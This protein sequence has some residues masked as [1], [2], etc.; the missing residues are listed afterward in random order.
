MSDKDRLRFFNCAKEVSYLSTKGNKQ[1]VRIGAV[2]VYKGRIVSSGYNSE[3]TSPIQKELNKERGFNVE[4]GLPTTH[5]EL[6]CI[7]HCREDIDWRKAE[8]FVYREDRN[9]LIAPSRCCPACMKMVKQMGI[10]KIN[11]T[12]RD[13][14]CSEIL[15]G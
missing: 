12:T 11:Y 1:K 9:G 3:K 13:G 8:L 15:K 4:V 10:K 7:I 2:L 14:Y 6:D 5:A